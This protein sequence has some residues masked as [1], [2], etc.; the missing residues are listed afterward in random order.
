MNQTELKQAVLI[1]K[2]C[3]ELKMKI[4]GLVGIGNKLSNQ[5]LKDTFEFKI[6]K[7]SLKK[8]D[9]LDSDGSL[10]GESPLKGITE[11]WSI[12]M[13]GRGSKSNDETKDYF[14]EN[15][16]VQESLIIIGSLLSINR[17]KMRLKVDQLK[18]LGISINA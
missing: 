1:I 16:S 15:L 10:Y 3:E 5:S 18:E 12:M 11:S 7:P 4:D 2:E 17:D 9:V 8:K 14:T 6:E 13:L